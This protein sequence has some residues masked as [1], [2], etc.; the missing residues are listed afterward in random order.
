MTI[1]WRHLW[2]TSK[3]SKRKKSNFALNGFSF[4]RVRKRGRT[5][6]TPSSLTSRASTT[7]SS[8]KDRKDSRSHSSTTW[9]CLLVRFSFISGRPY[10]IFLGCPGRNNKWAQK[11]TNFL[12]QRGFYVP[13]VS[14]NW[15]TKTVP[16]PSS[17]NF[18]S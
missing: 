13:Q 10:V 9:Y 1:V 14:I 16:K 11:L 17:N 2:T 15:W 18:D 5:T 7:S 8:R 3:T 6:A 12:P 4:D